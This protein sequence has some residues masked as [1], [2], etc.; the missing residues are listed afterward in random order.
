[1]N[2]GNSTPEGW[3]AAPGII[4]QIVGDFLDLVDG[5]IPGY[6]EGLY[7][8][9]SVALS[10]FRLH[11]SDID[12]VAVMATQPD[13]TTVETLSRVHA[14]V[15]SRYARPYFDGVYVTW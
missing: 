5:E 8:V 6:V 13:A 9:G 2:S 7:L 10:D 1:M 3:S 4:Q 15:Q 14:H 11:E 12:F